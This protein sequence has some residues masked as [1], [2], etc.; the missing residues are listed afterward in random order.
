MRGGHSAVIAERV[1]SQ[2]KRRGGSS[3]PV[4]GIGKYGQRAD[5]ANEIVAVG[6]K[7]EKGY[8]KYI[9][10]IAIGGNNRV[11]DPYQ[12]KIVVV[13]AACSSLGVVG[14]G[15]VGY[16]RQESIVI[17]AAAAA[18]D[19]VGRNDGVARNSRVDYNQL[20]GVVNSA[21]AVA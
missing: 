5:V 20:S 1:E 21:S 7:S 8:R 3:R 2:I 4:A 10:I 17:D 15:A 14:N 19:D 18:K 6:S 13:N 12:S 9:R 11:P 16:R